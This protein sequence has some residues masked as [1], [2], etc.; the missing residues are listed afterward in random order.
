MRLLCWCEAACGRDFK[1]SKDLVRARYLK[2]TVETS[3]ACASDY[4]RLCIGVK[5]RAA[6]GP[7]IAYCMTWAAPLRI[8]LGAYTCVQAGSSPRSVRVPAPGRSGEPRRGE[9]DHTH[10]SMQQVLV[11][12]LPFAPPPPLP[13]YNEIYWICVERAASW[14]TWL[15]PGWERLVGS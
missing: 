6:S 5:L 7:A 13:L 9:P 15:L 3:L 2:R 8:Y 14:L 10:A 12:Q 11:P 4:R 1:I